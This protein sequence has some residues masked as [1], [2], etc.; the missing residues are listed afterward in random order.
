V[1][2]IARGTFAEW[3]KQ[4]G[5]LGGQHKVPRIINDLPLFESLQQ[6]AATSAGKRSSSQHP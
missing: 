3:M 5:Q 6:F 1:V 4:R 2:A